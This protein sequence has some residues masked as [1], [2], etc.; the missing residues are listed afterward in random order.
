MY[1]TEPTITVKIKNTEAFYTLNWS[2][3]KKAD[4]YEI[5][6]QVPSVSGIYELYR[7]DETKKLNLLAVTHAWYGGLRSQLRA[8][9][10]PEATNDESKKELLEDAELYYRYSASNSFPDMLDVVWFLHSTY[11]P[12]DVRVENSGRYTRIYLIEKAPDRVY[13]LD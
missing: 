12:D 7:M 3:L 2:A 1:K 11:F 9:I 10:D 5:T 6:L 4:K 8:A 13:W